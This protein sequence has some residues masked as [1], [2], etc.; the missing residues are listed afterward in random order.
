MLIHHG[1]VACGGNNTRPDLIISRLVRYHWDRSYMTK[2]KKTFE[3]IYGSD[4]TEAVHNYIKGEWGRFCK[5]L[6]DTTTTSLSL[7][8]N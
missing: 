3:E 4:L 6:C 1:L 7:N 2:V 8:C 5:R